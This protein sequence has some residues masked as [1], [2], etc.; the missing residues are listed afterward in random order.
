MR[1]Q[2]A[3]ARA[4]IRSS[5]LR[6]VDAP[7]FSHPNPT[8]LSTTA[9]RAM[10]PEGRVRVLARLTVILF[11]ATWAANGAWADQR[12]QFLAGKTRDCP[13]CDLSGQNFKRRDLSGADLTGANLNN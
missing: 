1:T 8:L 7:C 12:E 4:C 5:L 11:A 3:A 6:G 13:R 10:M 9:A 2:P